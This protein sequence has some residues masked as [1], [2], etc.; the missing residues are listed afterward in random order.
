MESTETSSDPGFQ[1]EWPH[2]QHQPLKVNGQN[3]ELDFAPRAL[4][5]GLHPRRQQDPQHLETLQRQVAAQ[6]RALLLLELRRPPVHYL[7]L[8]EAQHQLQDAQREL[9]ELQ[10]PTVPF[11]GVLY[12]WRG[13]AP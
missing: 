3:L 7:E 11:S 10:D 5:A 13:E 4:V 8:R 6:Q 12:M 2:T 9:E 1:G